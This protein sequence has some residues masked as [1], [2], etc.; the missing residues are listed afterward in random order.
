[1]ELNKFIEDDMI[2]FLDREVEK[3]GD[4]TFIREDE[5][6]IF[7]LQKDYVK[8]IDELL[9]SNNVRAAKQLFEELEQMYAGAGNASEKKKIKTILCEVY[10]QL[11]NHVN[12]I[13]GEKSLEEKLADF[14]KWGLDRPTQNEKIIEVKEVPKSAEE[15]EKEKVMSDVLTEINALINE[16]A[17]LAKKQDFEEAVLKYRDL[18]RVFQELPDNEEKIKQYDEVLASYFLIKEYVE[19]KKAGKKPVSSPKSGKQPLAG[20]GGEKMSFSQP[21]GQGRQERQGE[22]QGQDGQ[23]P[24]LMQIYGSKNFDLSLKEMHDEINA[25]LANNDFE[26]AKFMHLEAKHVLSQLP[27]NFPKKEKFE[28]YLEKVSQRIETLRNTNLS[29]AQQIQAREHARP[30]SRPS[31][32]QEPPESPAGFNPMA[33]TMGSLKMQESRPIKRNA[34]DEKQL[35][36]H[37]VFELFHGDK[38]QAV[39]DF[40]KVLDMNPRNESAKIRLEEALSK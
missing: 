25:H 4:S 31:Q 19:N 15:I 39:Q 10:D 13:S 34:A 27:Q 28:E 20:A 17:I 30:H 1:M 29:A 37:G 24:H 38:S 16:I 14:E 35:Y 18:K 6:N 11:K 33:K 22:Q 2:A 3:R 26:K 9:K 32:R 23:E 7:N 36:L 12:T 8:E 5:F 40:K 21:S